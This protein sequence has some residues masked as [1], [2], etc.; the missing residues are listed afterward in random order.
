MR[1]SG[2]DNA[3][4]FD[5]NGIQQCLANLAMP[6]GKQKVSRKD[7]KEW[8]DKYLEAHPDQPYQYRG[9]D[10]YAA[11]CAFIHTYGADTALHEEDPDIIKFIYNSI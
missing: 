5:P 11:R 8:V 1:W 6:L 10:V 7:F 2:P 9:K 4:A 3:V